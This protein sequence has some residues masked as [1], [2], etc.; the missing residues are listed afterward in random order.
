MTE[1]SEVLFCPK[2]DRRE[3]FLVSGS[4]TKATCLGCET[5]IEDLP[6]ARCKAVHDCLFEFL[7]DVSNE[8]DK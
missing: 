7:A 6:T 3:S 2:C 1:S 5:E 8:V 4:A